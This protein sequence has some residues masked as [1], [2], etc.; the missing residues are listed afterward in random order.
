MTLKELKDRVEAYRVALKGKS[1]KPIVASESGPVSMG[2]IDA[3]VSV[4]EAHEK[5]MA[6]IE[7]QLVNR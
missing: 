5:R 6:E 4:L 2:L 7:S 3:V 1:G